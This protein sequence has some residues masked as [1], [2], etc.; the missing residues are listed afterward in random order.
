MEE[1]LI[2]IVLQGVYGP[3]VIK[4]TEWNPAMPGRKENPAL[5]DEKI[6]AVL[7]YI[8]RE[9]EHTAETVSTETVAK[10]GE[11]TRE[12]RAPWTVE[13]QEASR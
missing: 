11:D 4:G 9:W 10:M 3:M 5:T 12:K 13:E 7:T 1:R 8:R 6:A 2:R